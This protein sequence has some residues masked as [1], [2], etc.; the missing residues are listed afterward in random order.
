[1]IYN[2]SRSTWYPISATIYSIRG[3]CHRVNH[4]RMTIKLSIYVSFLPFVQHTHTRK[5]HGSLPS[6]IVKTFSTYAMSSTVDIGQ[7]FFS[8]APGSEESYGNFDIRPCVDTFWK[9]AVRVRA[10]RRGATATATTTTIIINN[11]CE[12]RM[13]SKRN[14]FTIEMKNVRN[15]KLHNGNFVF[16]RR[17]RA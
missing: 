4:L 8:F 2:T 13:P 9:F 6:E 10:D 7:F 1:M 12:I 15:C 16:A 3:H 17:V 11:Y 5:E 14:P